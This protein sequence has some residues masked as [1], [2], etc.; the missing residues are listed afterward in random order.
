MHGVSRGKPEQ[1]ADGPGEGLWRAGGGV[2]VSLQH[3]ELGTC[4]VLLILPAWSRFTS[5]GS[6]G[7]FSKAA[8]CARTPAPRVCSCRPAVPSG[9][10]GVTC[11]PGDAGW[12]WWAVLISFFF[13]PLGVSTHNDV[14]NA[15]EE[16]LFPWLLWG[17][18]A[19]VPGL[20][21]A[22]G[23]FCRLA[24]AALPRLIPAGQEPA[25]GMGM[26]PVVLSLAAGGDHRPPCS[27]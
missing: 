24:H 22:S 10:R 27:H 5:F 11:V 20:C 14:E 16:M 21:R 9:V 13:F 23:A 6:K 3:R 8:R 2:P 19:V 12:G 15:C 26:S 18:W 25:A 1:E 17:G 7:R 4:W